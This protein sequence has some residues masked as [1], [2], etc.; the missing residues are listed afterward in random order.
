MV[1]LIHRSKHS[2]G[3]DFSLTFSSNINDFFDVYFSLFPCCSKRYL[4]GHIFHVH[5]ETEK[6]KN[7]WKC[8]TCCRKFSSKIAAEKHKTSL[9]HQL[10]MQKRR[11]LP[12]SSQENH[13]CFICGENVPS[14]LSDHIIAKH[15]KEVI[16]CRQ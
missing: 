12:N 10:Q 13:S 2:G 8:I 14:F 3:I 16:R 11:N 15:P 4:K 9:Y 6:Y 5:R 1:L 7:S